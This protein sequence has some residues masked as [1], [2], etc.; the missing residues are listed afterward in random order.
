MPMRQWLLALDCTRRVLEAVTGYMI[1]DAVDGIGG[2][3]WISLCNL[4]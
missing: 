4:L 1:H 2:D 3:K